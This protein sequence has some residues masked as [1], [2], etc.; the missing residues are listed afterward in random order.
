MFGISGGLA[1]R[2]LDLDPVVLDVDIPEHGR[3]AAL[4]TLT[5]SQLRK[6]SHDDLICVNQMGSTQDLGSRRRRPRRP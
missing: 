4:L 1:M 3:T 5:A 6:P 2:F